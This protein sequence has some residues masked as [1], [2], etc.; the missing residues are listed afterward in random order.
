MTKQKTYAAIRAEL[1]EIIE[2]F[3]RSAHTDVD[4]LLKDY[5]KGKTLLAELEA[6]LDSAELKIKK[7]TDLA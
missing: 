1:D 7:A 5:E 6:M 4:E 3:E 2:R